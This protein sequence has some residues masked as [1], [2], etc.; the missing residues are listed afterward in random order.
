MPSS[1]PCY[2]RD[3][4]HSLALEPHDNF[5]V[6]SASGVSNANSSNAS[7]IPV[8]ANGNSTYRT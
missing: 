7:D 1:F 6:P 3:S 2:I 8:S 5:N 4:T